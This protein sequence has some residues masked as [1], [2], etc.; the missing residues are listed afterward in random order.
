MPERV[1]R[2]EK[3]IELAILKARETLE[4]LRDGEDTKLDIVKLKRPKAKASKH[5]IK[6]NQIHANAGGESFTSGKIKKSFDKKKM[7][8]ALR[9][10][11]R[12]VLILDAKVTQLKSKGP[13]SEED[14]KTAKLMTAQADAAEKVISNGIKQ[15]DRSRGGFGDFKKDDRDVEFTEA[16]QR[17]ADAVL[18]KL[19]SVV[20][21]ITSKLLTATGNKL[22][23]LEEDLTEAV[24]DLKEISKY[25]G[26]SS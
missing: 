21:D 3:I 22:G 13:M 1:T 12:A 6:Q 8:T 9:E 5:G 7:V 4:A 24:S 23:K 20:K 17:N 16:E 18:E 2:E 10:A 26:R 14:A 25:F 11:R 19:T 15:L